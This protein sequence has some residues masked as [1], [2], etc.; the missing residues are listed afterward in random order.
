[1]EALTM[2]TA[3][4]AYL[5]PGSASML[6]QMIGG[7]VVAGLVALKLF[8]GRILRFLHI[9]RK[10]SEAGPVSGSDAP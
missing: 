3:Y 4:I 7:G 6:L 5:D 8:W 9:G 10:P 2:T 1:M